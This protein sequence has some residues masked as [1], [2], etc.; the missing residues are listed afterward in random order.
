MATITKQ[1]AEFISKKLMAKRLEETK[2]KEKDFRLLITQMYIEQTPVEVIKLQKKY[3]DWFCTSSS[4]S[5]PYE[6]YRGEIVTAINAYGSP[7]PRICN[8]YTS[9]KLEIPKD[10]KALVFKMRNEVDAIKKK[11]KEDLFT[12]ENSL[13]A[14][15]TYARITEHFPEAVEYLPTKEKMALSINFTDVRKLI[16]L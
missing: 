16:K 15:K 13:N 10:Q 9:A 5:L 8:N 4:I 14:L 7:S 11:Y 2:S 1:E 12:I 3:P 6:D